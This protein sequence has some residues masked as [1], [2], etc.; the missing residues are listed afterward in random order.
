MRAR[1]HIVSRQCISETDHGVGEPSNAVAYMEPIGAHST[2]SQLRAS[3]TGVLQRAG[4]YVTWSLLRAVEACDR[5][6]ASRTVSRVSRYD[7]YKVEP[8]I[9]LTNG[10]ELAKICDT[11]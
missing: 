2:S 1:G 9:L 5:I 6:C 3:I 7:V 11:R 8:V 10:E 4:E